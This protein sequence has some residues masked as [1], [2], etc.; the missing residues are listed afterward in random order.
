[1]SAEKWFRDIAEGMWWQICGAVWVTGLLLE[2]NN[3][4]E[5]TQDANIEL[6]S[7]LQELEETIES[8]RIEISVFFSHEQCDWSWSI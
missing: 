5:K 2:L 6:V 4:T 1:L 3:T 8:Q 7:I